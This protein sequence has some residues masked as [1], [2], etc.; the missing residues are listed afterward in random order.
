LGGKFLQFGHFTPT[1]N[2]IKGVTFSVADNL[3]AEIRLNNAPIPQKLKFKETP[4]KKAA[5]QASA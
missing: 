1:L 2:D 5:S 3:W 4:L